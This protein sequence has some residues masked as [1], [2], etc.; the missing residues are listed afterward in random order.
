MA[1]CMEE[2][3]IFMNVLFNA[4]DNL[5]Y[6]TDATKNQENK[7]DTTIWT[8]R[9][10]DG[11]VVKE[12]DDLNFYRDRVHSNGYEYITYI[13]NNERELI[14]VNSSGNIKLMGSGYERYT[15]YSEYGYVLAY[16]KDDTNLEGEYTIDVFKENGDKLFTVEKCNNV[17]VDGLYKYGHARVSTN[18][19]GKV[20]QNLI[21]LNG[22]YVFEVGKY[23][24]VSGYDDKQ[25][26]VIRSQ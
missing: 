21:D 18:Y 14:C 5:F 4:G 23:A 25:A 13:N 2:V 6:T 22:N 19:N 12:F 8:L 16:K 20:T 1:I 3:Q 24:T 7:A 10:K 9:K 15:V 11:S 17:E 26:S